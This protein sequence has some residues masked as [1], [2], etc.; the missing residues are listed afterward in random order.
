MS[1]IINHIKDSFDF[2]NLSLA[3]PNGLQGGSYFTKLSN[4]EEPL[5]LQTIKCG[6]KQGIIRTAKKTYCDLMFNGNDNLVVEWFENLEKKL[7]DLIFEKKDLWFHTSL[8][9][10]DIESQFTSPIRVYKSGKHYLVRVNISHNNILNSSDFNCYDESGNPVDPNILKDNIDLEIIPLIEIQGIKF[11]SRSFA[12]EIALKQIMFLKKEEEKFNKCLIKNNNN[13]NVDFSDSSK[14]SSNEID[15]SVDIFKL[16]DNNEGNLNKEAI[17]E[18]ELEDNNNLQTDNIDNQENH[19]EPQNIDSIDSIDSIENIEN[20]ESIDNIENLEINNS[21][22]KDNIQENIDSLKD[23]LDLGNLNKE[24]NENLINKEEEQINNS[25]SENLNLSIEEIIENDNKSDEISEFEINLEKLKL[26]NDD[27]DDD[28]ENIL[29]LRKPNEV[30]TEIWREARKKAKTMRKA[31][32]EAYL[33]AKNIKSTYM[34]N[35]IDNE[36]SEDEF[37][38]WIENISENTKDKLSSNLSLG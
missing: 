32:I 19:E 34:I 14:D 33:E 26:N 3:Q 2:N 12:C 5:Y 7:V 17:E 18:N 15:T 1:Q 20:I 21:T 27:D 9:R 24:I 35:E 38:N 6:T 22:G 25:K 30:Y 28:S 10:E 8:D 37:D 4:N 31:A 16:N 29:K 11:S 13:Q 36:D 23:N